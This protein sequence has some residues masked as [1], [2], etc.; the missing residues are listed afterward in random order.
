MAQETIVALLTNLSLEEYHEPV[1][2]FI[3]NLQHACNR[4]IKDSVKIVPGSNGPADYLVILAGPG[5]GPTNDFAKELNEL[6]IGMK[7]ARSGPGLAVFK[8]LIRPQQTNWPD[9]IKQTIE[10]N[11]GL[12]A[13][14]MNSGKE[15]WTIVMD[16]AYWIHGM[17]IRR[18]EKKKVKIFLA[19]VPP[20]LD[21]WK[22]EIKRDLMDRG[23]GV[24]PSFSLKDDPMLEETIQ[25]LLES[26]QYS[27]HMLG[28]TYG[29]SYK[30][31]GRSIS[32]WQ[33]VFVTNYIKDNPS[34]KLNRLYWIPR[35]L[36]DIEV[37]Q[38][39]FIQYLRQEIENLPR[40]K[41]IQSPLELFKTLII[42]R[43]SKDDKLEDTGKEAG[44]RSLFLIY[45][46]LNAGNIEKIKNALDRQNPRVIDQQWPEEHKGKK[47]M[48]YW[49]ILSTCDGV[50]I[51]QG[52]S[53][54][55]W[56]SS[57]LKDLLKAPG[58]GRKQALRAVVVANPATLK[59]IP[60]SILP[61]TVETISQKSEQV[62]KTLKEFTKKL[63]A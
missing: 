31:T 12:D 24:E 43:I 56:L 59:E 5:E 19:E 50:V 63:F 32:E 2:R 35:E 40:T 52:K 8:I 22:E 4:V 54:K 16:V 17:I 36:E 15:Y 37:R 60:E 41:I 29:E 10:T 6:S 57:K 21:Q 14:S 13:F 49:N 55:E 51:Y 33:S 26:C 45:D 20:E 62:P 44:Q 23:F 9:P 28:H 47:V 46:P 38:E 7:G 61:G 18:D 3:G 58:F 25:K 42:K 34:G 48:H 39:Q 11:I 53:G 30:Q 27:I 1:N